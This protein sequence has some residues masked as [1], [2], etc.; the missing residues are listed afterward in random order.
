[1]ADILRKWIQHPV[2]KGLKL[3]ILL[4]FGGMGPICLLL[5]Q[6]ATVLPLP[7]VFAG[8]AAVTLADAVYILVSLL[9]IIGIIH[10]VKSTSEIFKKVNGAVI[11]YLGISFVLMS[12]TERPSYFDLYDWRAGSVFVGVLVLTMLNPV[13]IVCYTG[14]FNAKLAD[15]KMS[16]KDLFFFGFGT[17]LST[18]LFMT[19]VVLVGSMGG[20]FLPDIVI[21]VMN[22]IVGVLLILWGVQYI[23]PKFGARFGKKLL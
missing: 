4:Q 6:L 1:M 23:F 12:L 19:A 13:T 5:F 8:I 14:V 17:L 20:A 18:P 22:M 9:G 3:G 2:L 16:V 11:A 10:Q 15:L 21:N 7:D